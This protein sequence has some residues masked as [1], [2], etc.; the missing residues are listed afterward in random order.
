MEKLLKTFTDNYKMLFRIVYSF[1]GN[2]EDTKD[3]LQD[4]F[5]KAYKA[6]N[7]KSAN[8]LLPWIIVIAKNTA[9]THIR[10]Q[11]YALAAVND[12][13]DLDYRPDFL[14][15]W[16]HDAIKEMVLL[17]PEDLREPLRLHLIDGI[18]LK[19]LAK[20]QRIPYSRLLYWN[21][22][23]LEFIKPFLEE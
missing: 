10:R 21:N 1:A 18:A 23:L 9:R 17:V 13:V 7:S 2:T 19:R 11:K 16:I 6:Y 4:V 15:F 20:E 3:I 5:L 14:E 22:K 12:T 8:G